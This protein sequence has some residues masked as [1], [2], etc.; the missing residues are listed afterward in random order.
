M[1]EQQQVQISP[2][3]STTFGYGASSDK[4]IGDGSGMK[5]GKIMEC[6]EAVSE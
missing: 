5:R 1:T 6:K 4:G 2:L 3:K